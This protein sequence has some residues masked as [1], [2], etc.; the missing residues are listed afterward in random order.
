MNTICSNTTSKEEAIFDS[1]NHLTDFQE[2][3]EKTISNNNYN[4]PVK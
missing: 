3:A 4:Y 1:Q 2:I